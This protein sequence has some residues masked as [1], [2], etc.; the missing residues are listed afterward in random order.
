MYKLLNISKYVAMNH[1]EILKCFK[2]V[3]TCELCGPKYIRYSELY[4]ICLFVQN[5]ICNGDMFYVE[6]NKFSSF[7]CQKT[8]LN[9]C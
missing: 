9:N 1:T 2:L 8:S 5:V 3:P 4:Y 7:I 6:L